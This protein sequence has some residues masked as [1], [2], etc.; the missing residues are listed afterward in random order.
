MHSATDP[1]AP[2]VARAYVNHGAWVADCPVPYCT[3]A[4]HAG[5]RWGEVGRIA[6][7]ADGTGAMSCKACGWLGPVE[8]PAERRELETLLMQRPDPRTRNWQLGELAADLM[9]EN[10]R[11]GIYP[12][13]ALE[14]A[15]RPL[16]ADP[17]V[18][19]GDPGP[20]DDLT[21]ADVISHLWGVT[22]RR[23]LTAT[24]G[25]GGQ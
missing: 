1:R 10:F 19:P 12:E 8:W 15:S 24:T 20:G 22:E 25:N 3:G 14:A 11:H 13:S 6:E 21:A 5:I 16:D 2:L 17:A 4:E 23:A 7:R 18:R 9:G